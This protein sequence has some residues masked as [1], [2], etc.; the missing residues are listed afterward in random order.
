MSKNDLLRPPGPENSLPFGLKQV[1]GMASDPLGFLSRMAQYGDLVRYK[2]GLNDV[3]LVN[4]PDYAREVLVTQQRNFVKGQSVALLKELL[5]EGVFTGDGAEHLRRRRMLQPGFHK[6]RLAAF[7][8]IMV[9][10]TTRKQLTWQNRSEI[11]LTEEMKQLTLAIVTRTLFDLDV[12]VDQPELGDA[13]NALHTWAARFLLP[14]PLARLVNKLPLASNR[15]FKAAK[16]YLDTTMDALV[17]Q[18]RAE[19]LERGDLLSLLLES[20]ETEN[21][22]TGSEGK[23]STSQI[24]E[25]LLTFFLAGH[26]TTALALMWA[27]C[28][29]SQHPAAEAKLHRE[30]ENELAGGPPNLESLPRLPYTGQ[31]FSEALR[32]YPPAYAI[33]RYA[34]R[35]CRLGGYTIPSGSLVL[36]SPYLT[37]RDPRFYEE[38]E[39][40]KPERWTPEFKATLPKMAYFPFG[41]GPRLCIGES[42][43]MM[44]GVLVLAI[45]A[46]GWQMRLVPSQSLELNPKLTLRPKFPIRMV[47]QQRQSGSGLGTVQTES[48]QQPV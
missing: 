8:Q 23:L 13:L 35:P 48:L 10:Y 27:W 43:A 44:E 40:F 36:V 15:K 30:L 18:R 39:Q 6:E 1:L 24:R 28:L 7:A 33:P 29:L 42:F 26:E 25:E 14:V 4:H 41:G 21:V 9:D 11:D 20:A 17:R 46:Q 37:H 31:V 38:P 47:L 2:A 19:G 22:Q 45:L 16:L 12:A 32:L 3:Y 5:G 34:L